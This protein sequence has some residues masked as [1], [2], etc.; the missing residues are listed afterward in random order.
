M[1]EATICA[2]ALPGDVKIERVEQ[3]DG[4]YKWAV[5][6]GALCLGNLGEYEYEPMP[7]A[8]GDEFLRRCRFDSAEQ[9]YTAW[10]NSVCPL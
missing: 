5:R 10:E 9:A 3:L 8:R 2:Y 6:R 1:K 4:T 7:S